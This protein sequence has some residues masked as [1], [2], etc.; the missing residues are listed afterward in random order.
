MGD[1]MTGCYLTSLPYSFMRASADFSPEW[2]GSYFVPRSAVMPSAWL[3]SQIWPHADFWLAALND[4][5]HEIAGVFD[6]KATGAFIELLGW[7]RV[8]LLQDAAFLI[9]EFP[10]HPIFR[11]NVFSCEE[12]KDFAARVRRTSEE[13]HE[14]SQAELIQKAMPAVADKVRGVE[15]ELR[16]V[17][18]EMLAKMSGLETEVQLLRKENHERNKA[19]ITVI[20]K[21]SPYGKTRHQTVRY[22][23]REETPTPSER[24]APPLPSSSVSTLAL[25]ST[26]GAAEKESPPQIEFPRSLHTVS[27]LLRLWRY[28]LAG[29]MDSVDSLERQWGSEWR[30][31]RE[32]QLF[33]MRKV[34]VDEVV[35]RSQA[36]GWTE[37]DAARQLDGEKGQHS[38]DWLSKQLKERKKQKKPA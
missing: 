12:F 10:D 15:A 13:A 21:I 24:Q 6:N 31:R 5:N 19:E 23:Q 35:S 20:T 25:P 34:I 30:L 28:G 29:Y 4:P 26:T 36:N 11:D 9:C 1:S 7:L 8:V 38:L 32:R 37:E 22:D 3:R 18:T 14:D 2:S 16:S 27:E 17:K 33:S